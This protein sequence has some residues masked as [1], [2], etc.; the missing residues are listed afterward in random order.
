MSFW[1]SLDSVQ[2][3]TN[4]SA[5]IAAVGGFIAGAAGIIAAFA[6]IRAGALSQAEQA[7][8]DRRIEIAENALAAVKS[9]RRLTPRQHANIVEGLKRIGPHD[10]VI[11]S[12]NHDNESVDFEDDIRRAFLE[13]GWTIPPNAI[14]FQH[15]GVSGLWAVVHSLDSAPS[16]AGDVQTMF[17]SS[18]IPI[19]GDVDEKVPAGT[20][21]ITVGRKRTEGDHSA[22]AVIPAK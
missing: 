3:I 6:S 19:D 12:P 21:Q 15:K 17:I 10:I 1:N 18:G 7:K 11:I 2:R 9:P 5:V 4:G 14:I 8:T 20:M 22:K 16:Y 13:A